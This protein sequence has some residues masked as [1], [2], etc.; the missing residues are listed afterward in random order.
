MSVRVLFACAYLFGVLWLLGWEFAAFA[1]NPRY[2]I[3]DLWWAIEGRGWSF[4]R[5]F[6]VAGLTWLDLH[7]AFQWFR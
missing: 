2:T 7:L 6:T 1:V 5:Y 4:A 3:S